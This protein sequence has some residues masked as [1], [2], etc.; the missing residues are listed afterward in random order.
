VIG[1][2]EGL[3]QGVSDHNSIISRGVDG[4]GTSL[5]RIVIQ[6]EGSVPYKINNVLISCV[7]LKEF[8]HLLTSHCLQSQS[9]VRSTLRSIISAAYHV[10][11][12]NGV[13]GSLPQS[14]DYK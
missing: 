2:N 13:V 12:T 9:R 7:N 10:V 4:S 14:P 6:E 1:T 5:T 3:V 11:V 8:F